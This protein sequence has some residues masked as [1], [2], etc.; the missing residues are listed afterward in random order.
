MT[1]QMKAGFKQRTEFVSEMGK[2]QGGEQAADRFVVAI[3]RVAERDPSYYNDDESLG[4]S[5]VVAVALSKIL[6]AWPSGLQAL[7]K[8]SG[9]GDDVV[10]DKLIL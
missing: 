6:A 7:V 9:G 10:F 2:I 8:D 5:V 1:D 4:D 3:D